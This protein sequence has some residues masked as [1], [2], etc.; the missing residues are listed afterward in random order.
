MDFSI[1]TIAIA[2]VLGIFFVIAGISMVANGKATAAAV[3]ESVQN[4][5]M[6][7]MWG[8][9]ALLI[10][11]VIVVFNNVWT[12]GLALLVT[13]LGW[14]A[15]IKGM[16]ILL[17]PGAAASLYKKCGKSGLLVVAG[18]VM[19]VLGLILLYW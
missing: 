11:A 8:I 3:E 4:K 16:F 5:G 19:V 2:Q 13:I 7:F 10:G 6:M 18:V 12:S 1:T 9:L 14:L 15:L 17:L